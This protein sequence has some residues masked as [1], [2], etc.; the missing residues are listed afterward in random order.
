MRKFVHAGLL[1]AGV[2]VCLSSGCA[3]PQPPGKGK[4]TLL[5]EQT[6]KRHYWLYLPEEYMAQL[7]RGVKPPRHPATQNGLWPLVVSFHGMK[8]FDNC[9]PQAQEWQQESDRYGFIMIAPQ[10][11]T[12]DLLMQFPLNDPNLWYVREDEKCSVAIIKEV[13]GHMPVDKGRVLS[14]SWSSGGYMAHY[15]VNRHPDL[16]SCLAV[17]QSNFSANL[18]DPKRVRLYIDM[19]IGVFWT[20]N[21]FGICQSESRE[22]VKWYRQHRFK[23]LSWGVF[24]GLGHERTPQSAAALFAIQCGVRPRKPAEFQPLVQSYGRLNT[25]VSYARRAQ[26][27]P[28]IAVAQ[29]GQEELAKT[30]LSAPSAPPRTESSSR[31]G[32]PTRRSATEERPETRARVREP[33]PIAARQA[34]ALVSGTESFKPSPTVPPTMTPTTPTRRPPAEKSRNAWLVNPDAT[35]AVRSAQAPATPVRSAPTNVQETPPRV[36]P[37]PPSR[38]GN[39]QKASAPV[40]SSASESPVKPSQVD[41]TKRPNPSPVPAPI[42]REAL[43]APKR[44]A[45]DDSSKEFPAPTRR[46]ANPTGLAS[47]PPKVPVNPAPRPSVAPKPVPR[48]AKATPRQVEWSQ[49]T[50]PPRTKGREHNGWE[51]KRYS[52]NHSV[53]ASEDAASDDELPAPSIPLGRKSAGRVEV[54][55]NRTIGTSPCIVSFKALVSQEVA[56]GADFLWTDNG[57][58]I[59]NGQTGDK[60]LATSK[61]R[62]VHRIEVLVITADERELRGGTTVTVLGKINGQKRPTRQYGTFE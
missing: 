6:T 17:R 49:P 40:R 28:G 33:Q 2:V 44:I 20:Q 3:V 25:A 21:D 43:D 35:R 16:F 13:S 56:R 41:E 48:V 5:R 29:A 36:V 24:G 23:D 31:T 26:P 55:I 18:L 12:S 39:A 47:N 37:P 19:P 61:Q 62:E 4:L 7:N 38:T 50:P 15:M 27:R 11:N 58:P 32:R 14:T 10:L 34:P 45:M 30:E 57:V 54:Q 42:Q 1:M 9:L 46:T 8:P 52:N 59:C 51:P 22:A 60:I 53:V